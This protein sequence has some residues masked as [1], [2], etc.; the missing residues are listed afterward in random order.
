MILLRNIDKYT[1][2]RGSKG[3]V[4]TYYARILSLRGYFGVVSKKT[5][6]SL[7]FKKD[8]IIIA[9]LEICMPVV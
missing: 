7:N 3:R 2:M 1:C 8:M 6:V 5:S 9:L 4:N